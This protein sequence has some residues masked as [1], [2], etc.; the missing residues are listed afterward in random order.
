[1][2]KRQLSFFLSFFL[3]FR[4]QGLLNSKG[5]KKT[6]SF[7]LLEVRVFLILRGKKNPVFLLEVR[8]ERYY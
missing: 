5:Q 8:K 1:V 6:L 3:F 2:Y 7:F 4:S